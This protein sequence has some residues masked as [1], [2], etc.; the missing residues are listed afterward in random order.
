M[1]E[2]YL[3]ISLRSSA[4]AELLIPRTQ[5]AI[6]QRRAFS[7]TGPSAWSDLPV[8]LRLT[9]VA[10]SALF[11]SSLKTTLFDQGW[12]GSAPE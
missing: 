12:A 8:A 6:R 1:N 3:S 10:H 9:P 5:T 4:Q 11:L 2:L 7:V